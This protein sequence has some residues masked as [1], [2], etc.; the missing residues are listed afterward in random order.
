[1]FS[2][3]FVDRIKCSTSNWKHE[4]EALVICEGNVLKKERKDVHLL[5]VQCNAYEEFN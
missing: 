3:L 4:I 2:Y 1:M 5:Y